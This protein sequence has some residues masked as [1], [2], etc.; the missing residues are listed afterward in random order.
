[1]S[2]E[3]CIAS[4]RA[5]LQAGAS[6][7]AYVAGLLERVGWQVLDRNWRAR[8]GELDLV[9]IRDGKLRIVE[10]RA[11]QDDAT[12]PVEETVDHRKRARLRSAARSWLLEHDPTFDEVAFLVALVDLAAEPWSVTWID[13]AFDG[14]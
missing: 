3:S 13:D 4:R 7:E 1:M 2:H 8:G 12:V 5:A 10:V 6:A 14:S 9:V 11:R